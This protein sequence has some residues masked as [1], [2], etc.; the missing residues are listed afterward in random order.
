MS[1]DFSLSFLAK[2]LKLETSHQAWPYGFDVILQ[3]FNILHV[4]SF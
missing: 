3:N 2:I 4:T 1:L